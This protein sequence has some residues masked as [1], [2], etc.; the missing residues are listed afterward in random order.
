MN[1]YMQFDS[2]S[3]RPNGI[4]RSHFKNVLVCCFYWVSGGGINLNMLRLTLPMVHTREQYV[5]LAVN[6]DF[7]V[8]DSLKH[9][10]RTYWKNRLKKRNKLLVLQQ[11][12]LRRWKIYPWNLEKKKHKK[13]W[14]YV[15]PT[16][17]TPLIITMKPLSRPLLQSV[18]NHSDITGIKTD[19]TDIKT[20]TNTQLYTTDLHTNCSNHQ[21]TSN[22][23]TAIQTRRMRLIW[24][25]CCQLPS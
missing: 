24:K 14:D 21:E 5:L 22:L 9:H 16:T 4:G 15:W 1:I 23:S 11:W 19:I 7:S 13:T 6:L 20:E 12:S 3:S 10:Q 8:W 17:G 25:K 18:L 2:F